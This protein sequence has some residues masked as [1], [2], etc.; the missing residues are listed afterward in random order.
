MSQDIHTKARDFILRRVND[1]GVKKKATLDD[2]ASSNLGLDVSNTCVLSP[3]KVKSNS[4]SD[5]KVH[6]MFKEQVDFFANGGIIS[7]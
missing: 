4:H 5:K 7:R 6:K 1:I 2:S 3:M